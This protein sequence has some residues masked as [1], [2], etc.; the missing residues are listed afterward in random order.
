MKNTKKFKSGATS[1]YVVVIATLLFSVITV[2]F[3]RIIINEAGKTL[4]DELS[5]AAY[6]SALAGVEDAKIALK[7]Y[8]ECKQNPSLST[9]SNPV[10]IVSI[11]N[12]AFN[13]SSLGTDG[14]PECDKVARALGRIGE[15]DSEEV[16][17]QEYS[18][19]KIDS[20]QAY[21]CVLLNSVTA[22]YRSTLSSESTIRVI[23]LKPYQKSINEITGVRIS[24]F[25]QDN[26]NERYNYKNQD[27]FT[28]LSDSVPTP[29]TI[30]AQI[31]QTDANYNLND[32][33][34]SNGDKTDRGTVVLVG[35]NKSEAT[36]H[37]SRATI[38]NSNNHNLTNPVENV[39]QEVKCSE[40]SDQEFG[41]YVS[42]EIPDPVRTSGAVN[43]SADTFF[44]VLALPYGQPAT[45]FA[46]E[47]CTDTDTPRGDCKQGS[48]AAIAKFNGV[49]IAVDSTGRANDI[50]SRV[51]AR[52]EF[53]D[54]YFPFPEFAMLATGSNNSSI[55]KN[56]Y[57]T[58]NCWKTKTVN[59]VTT[60]EE[61]AN[62]DTNPGT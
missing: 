46:I 15:G 9:C 55:E 14:N 47:M 43:R 27:S 13:D 45:D 35:S 52:V 19:N 49:Q 50:Y 33:N 54:I 42:L 7:K 61:C 10:D 2:S 38:A 32:F 53:N 62:S 58:K 60:S 17:V 24:W 25:S 5:Q 29:S 12:S 57:V 37:I 3:V 30:S 31:I 18:S 59:G 22:D 56:F 4:S 16:L 48:S 51:E 28:S 8:E 21:T 34:D 36:N 26:S 20:V 11:I 41:C 23:P 6:D 1:I 39:P 44:L 40:S